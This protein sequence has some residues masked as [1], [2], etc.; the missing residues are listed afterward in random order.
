MSAPGFEL[1][2]T[3]TAILLIYSLTAELP[4]FSYSRTF[5]LAIAV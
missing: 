4:K 3:I 2:S 5:F 1:G